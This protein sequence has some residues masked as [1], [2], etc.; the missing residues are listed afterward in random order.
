MKFYYKEGNYNKYTAIYLEKDD[1][2]ITEP[3]IGTDFTL[4]TGGAYLG[5][6]VTLYN[7]EVVAISGYIPKHLWINKKIELPKVLY[8]A[9]IFIESTRRIS[10]RYRNEFKG[11]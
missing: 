8:K 9:K 3:D 10:S 11:K 1:G 5:I 4:M 2:I 7:K 6:D